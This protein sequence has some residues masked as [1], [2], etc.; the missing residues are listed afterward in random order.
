MK[1]W[2]MVMWA[3]VAAV[4]AVAFGF[5]TG[6]FQPGER[7]NGLWLVVAAACFYVLALRFY[8]RFL[9]T[10]VLELND[11][12]VTP[13]HRLHDGT[14]F[15]AANKY[16][17]F[18]H[19]FAAIAGAGPLLGP[20]LAAQFGFLPGFLW[21]VVGAVLA[22]AVQDFI[23]LVA[24]IR[25]NGR[26]LPEI[27]RDEIGLVTGSA[28]AV[29][30][31][32]IVVVAL[33]G[34]GLAVVNA[35]Y[36]NAWGTFTI[37]MTIPIAFLM[38]FYLQKFRTGRVGEV[39]ALGVS[40]LIVA[41]V[42]GRAV[43]QSDLAA[44]FD[45]EKPTIVWLLAGYGF[46]ASVLPMWM[47]LVPRDY[48]STF[49]KIGVVV[50][51]AL[52]VIV[53]APPIEMPRVT[54]FIH[55]GGPIIPGTMFPFVFITIACGA[56]SGFHSL[57]ASGTT[58]KM[59]AR[60]SQ[61]IVGYGAMLMESFVGV[62]ALIAATVLIPGDYLAINTLLS[63]DTLA[64]MGFPVARIE[65]LS[66]LV[67]VEVAGRP[68]G[69]VSLAVGMASIFAGLPGM[70][71]LMAYWYQFAL[72]FEALFILTTI[73]AGT[74]V[75]RYLVQEIGGRAYGPLRRINWWPGVIASSAA[76][77]GAWG[78]LIATGSISTIWPMFGAANQ[79]L[80]M[81][82]LCV[83]TTVLI[84]MRKARYLWV[85]AV[86]MLFVGAVTLTGA[87]ELF[88]LFVAK[89]GA[90]TGSD[91]ALPLV[92]DAILVAVVAVLAIIVLMDSTRKWYGYLVQGWPIRTT[93]V[94]AGGSGAAAAGLHPMAS[95]CL[96]I[97]GGR[98]C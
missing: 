19:H 23:I 91:Q 2:L 87:Y 16:V 49:M 83:G 81:L 8:G 46:L 66:R 51:L 59:I 58:P 90:A 30:V 25:R 24:S 61:A 28:V 10:Q 65:E 92:V 84:K 29:A 94:V 26:S 54:A 47:L 22:G 45:L 35:L 17:L 53:L 15:Y 55:G 98:C 56:I 21:L 39:S 37:A 96:D 74:R 38:G 63:A 6:V 80:G 89:A 3:L 76:V 85:T 52:G 27:A 71:G 93:E 69:A 40:L 72:L 67:E 82:A 97:P 11:Q 5:V 42:A 34:L 79:L 4:C 64:A 31:L 68:G 75:A 95:D 18:G 9:A 1:S 14:N 13:A 41:V 12:R 78:Y 60:E 7:V 70:A 44:W 77:V 86:P 32:F 33:A 20:V 62:M 88:F 73:D 50:L 43:A 48:L 57:V 36:R